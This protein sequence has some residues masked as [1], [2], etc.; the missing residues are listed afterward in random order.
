MKRFVLILILVVGFGN[1]AM[2]FS[3]NYYDHGPSPFDANNNTAPIPYPYGIG[4]M[5]S[6]GPYGEGGEAF[7]LEGFFVG[8]D[9]NYMYVALT[10]SFG[11][12]AHSSAWGSNFDQG[13]IFFGFNGQTNTFAID[14]DAAGDNLRSVDT[15]QG[16][17]QIGGSYYNHYPIRNRVGAFQVTSGDILGS[18]NRSLTFWDDLETN[19]MKPPADASGDTYVFE[20]KIDRSL[21]GWDGSS[22]IFFHTTLGCGNDL[23]EYTYESSIP[24]PGTMI[25]LGL[26][27]FGAGIAARRKLFTA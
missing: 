16:I 19:P 10:N 21:L 6:P 22:D 7:D 2:G 26:G 17:P 14:I 5:P 3:W 11:M 13:D 12:S 1:M 9:A 27:L 4:Y 25:L 24:E 23:I 18:A 8:F 20:W 15:Y